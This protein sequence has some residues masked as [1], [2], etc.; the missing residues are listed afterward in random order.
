MRGIKI[1]VQ[2]GHGKTVLEDSK[3]I[4]VTAIL[5]ESAQYLENKGGW[6]AGYVRMLEKG[7]CA[8]LYV[9]IDFCYY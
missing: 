3:Q 6:I 2:F 8:L 4:R 5:E 9:E 7:A 1:G